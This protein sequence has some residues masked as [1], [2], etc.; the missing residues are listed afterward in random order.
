M[1]SRLAVFTV[2][3]A[4]AV[5]LLGGVCGPKLYPPEFVSVPSSVNAGD[6]AWVRLAASG[7]G[8]RSVRY[9][10]NWDDAAIETTELY[11]LADTATLWHVWIIAP[12]TKYVRAAVYAPEDLQGIRWAPQRIVFVDVGGSH[13]PVM[14][15]VFTNQ[16]VGVVG[17][18]FVFT[19]LAHDPDGDSLRLM[20][21]WD[22][23]ETTS[24]YVASPCSI[25]VDHV[26]AQVGTA[27]FIISAQDAHGALSPP[28][29]ILVSVGTAGGAKWYWQSPE[30]GI[31]N[32]SLLCQYDGQD[33]C[34]YAS[35]FWDEKFYSMRVQNGKV[36]HYARPRLSPYVF[37]G[38]PAFC[39]AT[40]HFILGSEE[41]ELYALGLGLELAW[42]W[43]NA[44][45]ESLEP[46][47]LFG[48]PAI[49]DNRLYVPRED[50]SL[51]YF[52]DS[53]DHGV[54]VA[55]FPAGAGIV[56]A[57][58][59]DAQGNVYFGTDSGYLCKVGP[60]LDT[61]F[62]RTQLTAE[63]EIHSPIIGDDGT[64]F[65][66]SELS[67]IYAIDPATGSL[68]WT[69]ATE[70]LPLSL[71]ASRTAVFA[72]TD[73]GTVYSINPATGSVNWRRSFGQGFGFHAAPVVAANGY[74]YLQDD[75]DVLY[76][77]HQFDGTLIW[78]C[79]C[80][81]SLPGGVNPEPRRTHFPDY[82]P[83]PT[84]TSTG[85][86]IVPGKVAVFCIAGYT[87]GPLDPLAPW[88]KWQHDLY[89]SGYVGG[90]R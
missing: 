82:D 90:G 33:E 8:Y 46:M 37:T 26:F 51:Y 59:I 32:T 18:P 25:A 58:V 5:L 29:T 77:L 50:D 68:L 13:A 15:T 17:V 1:K 73:F 35:C 74:V 30:Q 83:S 4:A 6:T 34:V 44:P 24:M 41:G 45:S 56:D 64:I 63:A 61:L 19:V 76:C 42:R 43:P 48:A 80:N 38:Q 70:G 36:K 49:R 27:E 71:A 88:P 39:A 57:P 23:T 21:Q 53:I 75:N 79:D 55:T 12:D 89:N 7:R 84:I 69:A 78:A 54:R 47:V 3:V 10:V 85:D 40:Q 65:C 66:S 22:T 28:D 16:M 11:D 87:Q 86:I 20:L 31:F 9:A 14:D 62:W 52:I 2:V 72:G 81:A 67:R 60:E